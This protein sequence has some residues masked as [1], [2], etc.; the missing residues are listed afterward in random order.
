MDVGF[1]IPV[2]MRFLFLI[3]D[4]K[5]LIGERFIGDRQKGNIRKLRET[6]K[7]EF[8]GT[9]EQISEKKEWNIAQPDD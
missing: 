8:F 7:K 9:L 4:R 3:K 5:F 1:S 6:D 2:N